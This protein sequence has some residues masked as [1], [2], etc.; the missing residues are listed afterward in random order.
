[1]TTKKCPDVPET[2]Q[3]V[4]VQVSCVLLCGGQLLLLAIHVFPH[5]CKNTEVFSVRVRARFGRV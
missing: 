4:L 1:M 5:A 3:R 2:F